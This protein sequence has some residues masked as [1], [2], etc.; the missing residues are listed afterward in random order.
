MGPKRTAKRGKRPASDDAAEEEEEVPKPSTKKTKK[1]PKS[2]EEKTNIG[3]K[4]EL[5]KMYQAMKYQAKKGNNHP[6][7]KYNNL[8]TKAEKQDFYNKYLKDKKFERFDIEEKNK[9]EKIQEEKGQEGWMS[10]FQV[11]DHEKMA[12]DHPLMESKLASLPSR[13]HPIQEWADKGEMEYYYSSNIVTSRSD[14]SSHSTEIIAHGTANKATCDSMMQ[15]QMATPPP[16]KAIEDGQGAADDG[17]DQ[18]AITEQEADEKHQQMMEEWSGLKAKL[19]KAT[20]AMGEL[21]NEATTV[22]GALQGK[23]HFTGLIEE[24]M[25]QYNVFE[26]KKVEALQVLGMM[27]SITEATQMNKFMN[28]AKTTWEDSQCHILGF[29]LGAF[30]EAKMLVKS[31]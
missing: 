21:S 1:E 4:K 11:A 8:T 23:P 24:I 27:N 19:Q 9:A 14:K 15:S 13:K 31:T 25:K 6:L 26:P 17:K 20:K 12:W 3:D 2:E 30:K 22:Q 28:K 29:K 5:D 10:K 7:E 18:K 16:N